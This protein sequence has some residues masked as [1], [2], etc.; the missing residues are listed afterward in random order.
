MTTRRQILL[1]GAAASTIATGPKRLLGAARSSV[2]PNDYLSAQQLQA[3]AKNRVPP[4]I[5]ET[6]RDALGRSAPGMTFM[7]PR[8]T[9]RLSSAAL[10]GH[11]LT[12][13][14]GVR[15]EGQGVQETR[16]VVTGAQAC[17]LF[18]ANDPSDASF[19]DFS[20]VG[21]SKS[22]GE[23]V[24][25]AIVAIASPGSHIDGLYIERLHL[26]NFAAPGWVHVISRKGAHVSRLAIAN[27]SAKSR[28]GNSL[29]P[30]LI[31]HNAA[32][33]RLDGFDGT[34]SD[35]SITNLEIDAA[36]IKSGLAAYGEIAGL[37][38]SDC[39]IAEAGRFG[40]DDDAGGYAL[41]FYAAGRDMRNVSLRRAEIVNP[42]SCGIYATS[43]A[44]LRISDVRIL[45]QTDLDDQ[46]LP[47]GGIAL[48]GT[49]N[50]Q[51]IRANLLENRLGVSVTSPQGGDIE[52]AISLSG[53]RIHDCEKA[54][55]FVRASR[56]RGRFSGLSLAGCEITSQGPG[57]AVRNTAAAVFDD[58]DISKCRIVSGTRGIDL[59]QDTATRSYFAGVSGSYVSGS[60]GALRV[61]EAPARIS[62]VG[63]EFIS[64]SRYPPLDLANI[65]A[66]VVRNSRFSEAPTRERLR[67]RGVR[68]VELS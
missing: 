2:A 50:V 68:R 55:L 15:I 60:I 66:L 63:S 32:V 33:I 46:T 23:T 11:G 6:L 51:I 40:A 9:I 25:A 31:S 4:R 39:Q 41:Q 49:R 44:G 5:V 10:G 58:I 1:A 27:L 38:I 17:R 36:H 8:G 65:D 28:R 61:R 43:V 53:C 30:D 13:P 19:A 45:G 47:K 29:G 42:R 18:V 7:L 22:V 35:I 26:E 34:L 20:L 21:N 48:N 56:Q 3:I 37:N 57:I 64:G 24:G 16:V 62:L 59:Y 12:V 14:P 52:I 54:G 67:A